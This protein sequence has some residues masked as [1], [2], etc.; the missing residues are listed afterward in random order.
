M[1]LA[2]AR[3][4]VPALGADALAL[5]AETLTLGAALVAPSAE[6]AR[7]AAP[8]PGG[9]IKGVEGRQHGIVLTFAPTG[10]PPR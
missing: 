7:D 5:G 3:R 2:R 6:L 10:L 4:E 9:N 1:L 8:A